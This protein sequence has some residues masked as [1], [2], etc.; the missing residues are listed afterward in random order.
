[1]ALYSCPKDYL[2]TCTETSD[3]IKKINTLISALEDSAIRAAASGEIEEYMLDDG[4]SKIRNVYR[5]I[6]DIANAILSF[7]KIREMLINRMP[8]NRSVVLRD[9]H[10][11]TMK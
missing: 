3:K 6:E 9:R 5:S 8:G 2:D 10:A 1:M 11:N 4:Q 7:E